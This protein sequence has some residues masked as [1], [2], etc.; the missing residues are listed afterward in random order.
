MAATTR[1]NDLAKKAEPFLKKI[2]GIHDDIESLKGSF[3][4]ACKG[5]RKL[6]RDAYKAAKDEGVAPTVLKGVVEQRQL[7]NKIKKIPTDFDIDEAAAY[8]ELAEAFGD[9]GMAAAKRAGYGEGEARTPT[10][11]EAKAA[12]Q[13]A[14]HEAGLQT[15]GRGRKPVGDLMREPGGTLSS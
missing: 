12:S 2:E 1:T 5:K 14:A 11:A 10:A 8:R 9:L 4:S 6:I 7:E 3:M 15:V 13:A